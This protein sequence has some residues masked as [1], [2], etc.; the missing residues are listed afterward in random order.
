[1]FQDYGLS[2]FDTRNRFVFNGLYELPFKG[3]RLVEG[4]R[5]S[6]IL[7][8][9]SGNPLNI[10]AGAPAKGTGANSGIPA[11][12]ASAFTGVSRNRPDLIAPP[13][14]VNQITSAG[15]IQ[16]LAPNS[17]CDPRF[18]AC[19]AGTSYELPV[20]LVNGVNIYHFGDMTRNSVIGPDFKNLD[21][22]LAKNTKLTERLSLELRA[23]AFDAIN[24]PNFGNPGLTALVGSTSF[25]VINSTRFPNGDSGSARQLQ[26]AAKFIF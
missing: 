6:G 24:H 4:W 1:M 13:V 3:N 8:L 2:D 20:A 9:Q 26:F 7:T 10:L 5:F 12:S 14:I 15:L 18:G 19:A 11:G 25:G 21:L 23:E 16:W 22:S 17:V